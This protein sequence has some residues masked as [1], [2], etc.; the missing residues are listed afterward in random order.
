MLKYLDGE[1]YYQQI[2][3][4]QKSLNSQIDYKTPDKPPIENKKR[5][6]L[7]KGIANIGSIF[8]WDKNNQ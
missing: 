6:S 7:F 8:K 5:G 3:N 1:N 2:N 4:F